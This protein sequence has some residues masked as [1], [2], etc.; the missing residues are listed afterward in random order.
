MYKHILLAVDGSDLAEAAA[1]HGLKLAKS[2]GAKCTAIMALRPWHTVAP[3]EIMVAFPEAEYLKGATAYADVSVKRV[4]GLA[5]QEGVS[6][7]TSVVSQKEPWEAIAEG[8]ADLG[9]DLI[10]MGSHGRSGFAKLILGSEAQKV[11]THA[12]VPVLVHRDDVSKS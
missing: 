10:V 9:C 5:D 6:C 3:G 7:E 8:A 11:L 12:T 1:R 2:V 4:S